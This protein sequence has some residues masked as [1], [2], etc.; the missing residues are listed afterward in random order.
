MPPSPATPFKI[1]AFPMTHESADICV[2]HW[3]VGP[4]TVLELCHL[5]EVTCVNHGKEHSEQHSGLMCQ[6]ITH[7]VILVTEVLGVLPSSAIIEG[8]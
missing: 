3:S 5:I 2:C 1:S 7:V 8:S 4:T 6:N